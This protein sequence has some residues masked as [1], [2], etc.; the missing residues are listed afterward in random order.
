[1]IDL[2]P[3]RE[4]PGAPPWLWLWIVLFYIPSLPA[5]AGTWIE[6]Y[7]SLV[8]MSKTIFQ[9]QR[10]DSSYDWSNLLSIPGTLLENIPALA[11]IIGVLTVCLPCLRVWWVE[12]RYGLQW[13]ESPILPAVAEMTAFIHEQT[14]QL[15]I[16]VNQKSIVTTVFVYPSGWRKATVALLAPMTKL[17]R[18]NRQVAEAVLL[19][20]IAHYRRGDMLIVGA[21]S[22]LERVIKYLLV[23]DLVVQLIIF[24]KAVNQYTTVSLFLLGTL[25]ALST[26]IRPLVLPIAAIWNLELNADYYVFDQQNKS[27]DIYNALSAT[28]GQQSTWESIVFLVAHPPY[29]LRRLMI[30]YSSLFSLSILLLLFP[31]AY[32]IQLLVMYGENM[33][34]ILNMD[35]T[36]NA[37]WQLIGESARIFLATRFP[38]WLTMTIVLLLWPFLFDRWERLFVRDYPVTDRSEYHVYGLC[39]SLTA[40]LCII[41]FVMR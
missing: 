35:Y 23:S 10:I 1:M 6:Q 2:P 34:R 12:W 38:I 31:L 4:K 7:R 18:S 29:H 8:S 32:V 28:I 16:K 39:A 11:L 20:E 9:L 33:V 40:C 19:H 24:V 22:A 27:M 26:F 3:R 30:K 21:G 13:P 14:P 15:A 25:S 5:L 37:I 17:W 36:T 41:S